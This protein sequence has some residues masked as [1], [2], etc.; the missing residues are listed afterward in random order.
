M[1]PLSAR[2][3]DQAGDGKRAAKLDV[4]DDLLFLRAQ[5]WQGLVVAPASFYSR[6][7]LGVGGCRC[8]LPFRS[9]Q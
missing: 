2:S 7:P 3:N 1:Q 5:S 6:T 8:H 9:G 4:G